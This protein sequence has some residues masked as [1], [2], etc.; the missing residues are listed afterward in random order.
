MSQDG[1]EKRRRGPL[2]GLRRSLFGELLGSAAGAIGA[3]AGVCRLPLALS[4]APLRLDGD[5]LLSRRR[6]APSGAPLLA[7]GGLSP[8][9]LQAA[10]ISPD[11][12]FAPVGELLLTAHYL[13]D[14]FDRIEWRSGV[15]LLVPEIGYFHLNLYNGGGGPAW[16]KRWQIMPE[17][18]S[19]PQ[20]TDRVW[21][22]GGSLALERSGAHGERRLQF[23]PQLLLDLGQVVPVGERI[24]AVLGYYH[25]HGA[26]DA[27]TACAK[28]LPQLALRWLN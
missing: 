28:P 12:A 14:D 4:D 27:T 9:L 18:F 3:D 13:G 24:E 17:G 11:F 8:V 10:T 25:W 22:L 6:S 20:S 19:L 16:S 7:C 15:D 23:V 26:T 2:N 21:S 1:L 5:V